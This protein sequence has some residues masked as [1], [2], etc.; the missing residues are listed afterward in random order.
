MLSESEAREFAAHW[1]AA[2]NAHDLEAI[3]SHYSSQV[4]LTSPVAAKRFNDP[5]G[6]VAGI[7]ALQNYFKLGLE[8]YP[9]LRFELLDVMWGISS[10]V[11]YYKNHIGT[12]TGEFMELD[13]SGKVIRV[14][15]NYGS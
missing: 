5:A 13:S 4:K 11:L 9:Q 2:W 7:E 1:I 14:V 15:A 8:A 10:V 6:T 3:L 12:M